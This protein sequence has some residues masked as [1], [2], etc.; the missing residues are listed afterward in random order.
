[1]LYKDLKGIYITCIRISVNLELLARVQ[2]ICNPTM[3]PPRG[4]P[5]QCLETLLTN[6]AKM[7][8]E[9]I[10]ISFRLSQIFGP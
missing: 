5:N 2:I 10:Y 8:L 3:G 1:M 9:G 6:L 4:P 7:K